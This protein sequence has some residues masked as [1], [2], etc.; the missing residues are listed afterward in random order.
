MESQESP[1][2]SQIYNVKLSTHVIG[3]AISYWR[4]YLKIN[5]I[6]LKLY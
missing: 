1:Y 4:I 5:P 3:S 6:G 2:L